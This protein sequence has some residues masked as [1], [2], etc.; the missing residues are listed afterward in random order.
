MIAHIIYYLRVCLDVPD[1]ILIQFVNNFLVHR[2][3]LI[4]CG[5]LFFFQRVD[6]PKSKT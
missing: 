4:D 3:V 1:L 5:I 2:F 6:E